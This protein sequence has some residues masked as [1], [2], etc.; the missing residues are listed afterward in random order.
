[1]GSPEEGSNDVIFHLSSPHIA[2]WR[3]TWVS[4][5][6]AGLPKRYPLKHV[7]ELRLE[8]DLQWRPADEVEHFIDQRGVKFEFFLCAR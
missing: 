3:T 4:F 5:P 2:Q 8:R 7:F 1:M 6:S